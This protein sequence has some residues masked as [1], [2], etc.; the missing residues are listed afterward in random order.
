[1]PLAVK[2][3]LE[4]E[5]AGAAP[6]DAPPEALRFPLACGPPRAALDAEGA[7]STVVDVVY[8]AKVVAAAA[9]DARLK[10]FLVGLALA[11]VGAKHG[12]TLDARYKL[13]RRRYM[14]EPVRPQRV[15]DDAAGGARIQELPSSAKPSAPTQ[16][17]A[18]AA[19]GPAP[20]A[21]P[22]FAKAPAVAPQVVPPAAASAFSVEFE[23]RPCTALLCRTPLPA[24][25]A[26]MAAPPLRLAL[27]RR[28]LTLHATSAGGAALASLPLPFEVDAPRASAW[29]ERDPGGGGVHLAARLPVLPY[30]DAARDAAQRP[31]GAAGV[32]AIDLAASQ[33]LELIDDD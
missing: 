26:A 22:L 18:K 25:L 4:A 15:R 7:P 11:H 19:S 16:P 1:V 9:S 12:W 14:D 32:G 27:S 10:A 23:G 24:A 2:E 33:Y 30:G 21:S 28:A 13:P 29:L 31:K 3:A 17:M 8:A 5:A 20:A 6:G